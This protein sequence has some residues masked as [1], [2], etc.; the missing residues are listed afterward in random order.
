VTFRIRR[1]LAAAWAATNPVLGLGEPGIETD[2]RRVKY[3][4]GSAAWNALPYANGTLAAQDAGN[5]NITGGSITGLAATLSLVPASGV[6]IIIRGRPADGAAQIRF[7]DANN[8]VQSIIAFIANEYRV[9]HGGLILRMAITTAGA[10]NPGSDNA[11]NLGSATARWATVFAGTGTINTSDEREKKFIGSIPDAWLDAWGNVQW[12]RYQMRGGHRWHVGLVAQRVRDA[13]E[14]H[15]LDA[16][17]IGLLCHDE[18][19]AKPAVRTQ[20]DSEGSVTRMAEAGVKAGDRWG[21]RYDECQAMEAA[22]VRRELS[23]LRA[24]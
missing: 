22:W 3:G 20:H 16:T 7:H 10:V 17:E 24:P 1:D 4:N 23:R 15:G 12:Q 8:T 11:Q 13:F 21:L 2:T 14:A 6:G 19:E 5:V 9:Y 18:W